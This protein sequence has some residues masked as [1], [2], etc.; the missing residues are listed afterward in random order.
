[1]TSSYLNFVCVWVLAP[2]CKAAWYDDSNC[3]VAGFIDGVICLAT[4]EPNDQVKI[5]EAHK[6]STFNNVHKVLCKSIASKFIGFKNF[7][8]NV[9]F[10]CGYFAAF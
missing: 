8:G 3:F 9:A 2:V 4:K 5:V 6:V 7:W 1:M 10:F